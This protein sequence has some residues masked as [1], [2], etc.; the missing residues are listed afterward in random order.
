MFQF[1]LVISV[2]VIFIILPKCGGDCIWNKACYVDDD[3]KE[4][5]CA[6]DGPGFPITDE[7][8]QKTM[9]RLCPELYTKRT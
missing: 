3:D 9:E 4:F 6:Y 8:A 2:S 5:Y 1:S 7:S